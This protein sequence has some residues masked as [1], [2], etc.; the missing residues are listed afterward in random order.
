MAAYGSGKDLDKGH[1]ESLLDL[2]AAVIL[3][4]PTEEEGLDVFER[5]RVEPDVESA[6]RFVRLDDR[7]IVVMSRVD[8]EQQDERFGCTGL[9]RVPRGRRV[10]TLDSLER[11]D[12]EDGGLTAVLCFEESGY[13]DV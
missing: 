8:L 9:R 13:Q 12:N 6:L 7:D 3:L 10:S 2:G 4:L 11:A 1:I 5:V